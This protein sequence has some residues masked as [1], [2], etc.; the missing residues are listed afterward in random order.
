[1]RSEIDVT[2]EGSDQP[3]RTQTYSI[4]PK[5]LPRGAALIGDGDWKKSM[6]EK[7]PMTQS[8]TVNQRTYIQKLGRSTGRDIVLKID[9]SSVTAWGSRP[10]R[11]GSWNVASVSSVVG[12]NM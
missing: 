8:L 1:M 10:W 2:V 9:G 5:K 6:T 4:N 7:V 12:S 3:I 11:S